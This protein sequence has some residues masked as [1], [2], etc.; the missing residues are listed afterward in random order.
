MPLIDMRPP[1]GANVGADH[2]A[3]RADHLPAERNP[4]VG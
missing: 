2:P 1:I 4:G 3:P